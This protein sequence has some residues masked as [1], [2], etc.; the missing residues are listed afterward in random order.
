L[1]TDT[2]NLMKNTQKA[3]FIGIV[4]AV[5]VALLLGI[6]GTY[7]ALHKNT[8][9][10]STQNYGN[11]ESVNQHGGNIDQ[12]QTNNVDKASVS[13]NN[14]HQSVDQTPGIKTGGAGGIDGTLNFPNGSITVLSPK[15]G[16]TYKAGGQMM[17]KWKTNN[18]DS[19]GSSI[20]IHLDT[21]DG[22][23]LDN[24]NLVSSHIQNTGEKI[25]IIPASIP[26][27]Q[28]KIAVSVGQE[29]EDTS[30]N[31]FTITSTAQPTL[32]QAQAQALVIQSWGGCTPDTCGSVVV[33]VQNNNGTFTVTAIYEGLRDD[34]SS[35]QKKVAS[36]YYSNGVWALG[37]ATI[38][39][40]CQ[41][42]R[43]HQ[44][45]SAALCI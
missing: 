26:A 43:G 37:N 30:D 19:A 31:Y 29:L 15:G 5:A 44:D 10:D 28:Y 25:V 11:D 34:S 13:V 18:V 23:H 6:G 22:K 35:A 41:P 21:F 16:E 17:V 36:A 4:I 12:T 7:V 40:R 45:F 14:S 33:T 8:T 3:G 2:I 20:W 32:T 27:G 9:V 38:T 24:G 39:Q 42:G 1:N